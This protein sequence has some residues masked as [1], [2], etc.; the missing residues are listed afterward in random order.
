MEVALWI[1]FT[2][3]ISGPVEQKLKFELKQIY[4]G[5]CIN[6]ERERGEKVVIDISYANVLCDVNVYLYIFSVQLLS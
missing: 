4:K 1:T 2:F 3:N 5:M 6:R